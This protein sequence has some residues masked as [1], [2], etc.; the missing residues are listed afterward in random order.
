[1]SLACVTRKICLDLT[2]SSK[3]ACLAGN[4]LKS[5][6]ELLKSTHYR[7]SSGKISV[8]RAGYQNKRGPLLSIMEG[9]SVLHFVENIEVF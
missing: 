2:K 7:R 6:C 8:E 5:F 4:S 9:N 3:D 1:M